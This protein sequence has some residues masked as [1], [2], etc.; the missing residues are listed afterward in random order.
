[1]L[2]RPQSRNRW[3]RY[4]ER[5]RDGVAVAPVTYDADVVEA[6]DPDA[7]DGVPVVP[8]PRRVAN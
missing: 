3:K 4:R 6:A 2:D 7:F 1:M 8:L 5:Q